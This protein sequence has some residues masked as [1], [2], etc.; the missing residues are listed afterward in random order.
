M[1]GSKKPKYKYTQA[2]VNKMNN[3]LIDAARKKW[4]TAVGQ[5]NKEAS[6]SRVMREIRPY[7]SKIQD[8]S[9][10]DWTS[11]GLGNIERMRGTAESNREALATA[12]G[13]E[14]DTSGRPDK[15]DYGSISLYDRT[16][17][18]SW[19]TNIFSGDPRLP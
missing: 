4:T 7:T 11:T 10:K 15:A 12:M 17:A 18:R 3:Q 13:M 2:Q 6:P 9:K 1:C 8:I 16:G 19:D 5:W 14:F